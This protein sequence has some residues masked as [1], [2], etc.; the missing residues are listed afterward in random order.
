[1]RFRF[2][3]A[4]ITPTAEPYVPALADYADNALDVVVSGSVHRH[5]S[6]ARLSFRTSGTSLRL[7]YWANFPSNS[8]LTIV[9]NGVFDQSVPLTADGAE[10][11]V[12][13]T[14]P[15]GVNKVVEVWEGPQY[16]WEPTIQTGG[17]VRS[18]EM[19]DATLVKIAPVPPAR[20]VVFYGDSISQAYPYAPHQS[21]IGLLR[22]DTT[23]DAEITSLGSGG[24]ALFLDVDDPGLATTAANIAAMLADTAG[25]EELVFVMGTNDWYGTGGPPTSSS[26]LAAFQTNVEDLI[27]A[28]HAAR[29]SAIVHLVSPLARSD[30]A[31]PNANGDVLQDF[32]DVL[33]SVASTRS[34]WCTYYDASAVLNLGTDYYDGVHLLP[35]GN[36]N[37]KSWL[38]STVLT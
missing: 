35:V 23:F 20:R 32:R 7:G 30:E 25:T 26:T 17:I 4:S 13:V 33:E 3:A 19:L 36:T 21:Y 27:D 29:P 12:D 22:R 11:T 9:V 2:P 18:I 15:S 34:A 6:Y 10:H 24:R 28:V 16:A 5:N 31:T 37:F 38:R 8:W 1:M 14:L